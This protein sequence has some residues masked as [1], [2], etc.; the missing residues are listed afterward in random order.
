MK[1]IM[2]RHAEDDFSALLVARGMAKAGAEV[3]SITNNGPAW[4]QGMGLVVAV[5]DYIRRQKF[6]VW[7]RVRDEAH[8]TECDEAISKCLNEQKP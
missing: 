7:A 1:H 5:E 4:P 3:F 2:L 6:I 8:I